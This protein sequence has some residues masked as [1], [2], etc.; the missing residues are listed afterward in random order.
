MIFVH[1]DFSSGGEAEILFGFP[2]VARPDGKAGAV[3]IV[4]ASG[5]RLTVQSADGSTFTFDAASRT[6]VTQ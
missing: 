6:F 4:A 3:R 5:T 2:L 1:R